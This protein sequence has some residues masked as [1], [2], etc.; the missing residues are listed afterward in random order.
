MKEQ[1]LLLVKWCPGETN[2]SD[3]FTKILGESDFESNTKVF[4][5]DD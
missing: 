3:V 4:C 2:E 1:G 5:K